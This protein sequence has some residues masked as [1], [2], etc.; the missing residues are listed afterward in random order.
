MGNQATKKLITI[1]HN[2]N[3]KTICQ[4]LIGSARDQKKLSFFA[5][6]L[7]CQFSCVLRVCVCVCL[8]VPQIIRQ[9]IIPP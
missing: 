2:E 5:L 8:A 7:F 4:K 1:K 6:F 9:D 3:I